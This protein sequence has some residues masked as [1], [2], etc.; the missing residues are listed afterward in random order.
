MKLNRIEGSR[1]HL[2][3]LE[4]GDFFE[5]KDGIYVFLKA[6]GSCG[7]KARQLGHSSHGDYPFIGKSANETRFH[8]D[9][10]VHKVQ[11]LSIDYKRV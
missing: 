1:T 6:Y 5:Y 8:R 4:E 2:S 9:L 3:D 11:I 7:W 10:E